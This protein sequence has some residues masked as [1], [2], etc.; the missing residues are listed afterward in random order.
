MVVG[1]QIPC[2]YLENCE[3][4][5]VPDLLVAVAGPYRLLGHIRSGPF[6]PPGLLWAWGRTIRKKGGSVVGSLPMNAAP[7]SVGTVLVET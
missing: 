3:E 1:A 7:A 5:A 2:V 6:R 4:M